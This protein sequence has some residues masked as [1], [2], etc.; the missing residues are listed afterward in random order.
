MNYLEL[1]KDVFKKNSLKGV[2]VCFEQATWNSSD[3]TIK[4]YYHIHV[5]HDGMPDFNSGVGDSHFEKL[6]IKVDTILVP[7]LQI[8]LTG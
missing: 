8:A 5:Q 6:L 1:T 7:E 4:T 3:G 2:R